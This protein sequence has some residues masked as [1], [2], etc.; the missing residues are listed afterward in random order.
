MELFTHGRNCGAG[1]QPASSEQAESL[2]HN[3]AD[4]ADDDEP[5]LVPPVGEEVVDPWAGVEAPAEEFQADLIAEVPDRAA[6]EE[7]VGTIPREVEEPPEK[8]GW[9]VSILCAGIAVIS[10]CLLLPLAEENHQ[11]A[12]QREK[13]KTDLVQLQQQVEINDEFLKKISNDPTL[14]ERLAQRQMKFVREGSSILDLPVSGN[15][16]MSPF[17]LV[18]LPNPTPIPPYQPL[19]G[20]MSAV[21]RNP[22]LRLYLTGIGLLLLATGLVLGGESKQAD[23]A[24]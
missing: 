4:A 22:H 17:Q 15:E 16:E 24:N 11:L 3:P 7:P 14:A 5:M 19:G 8:G 12:W 23:D 9:M 2:H 20:A 13:L 21:V 6:E 1:F 18:S 10:I